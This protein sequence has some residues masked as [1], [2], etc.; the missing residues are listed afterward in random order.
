MPWAA[1]AAAASR[2]SALGCGDRDPIAR[3]LAIDAID[4]IENRSVDKR[5]HAHLDRHGRAGD[6]GCAHRQSGSSR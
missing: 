1:A 4:G 2:R 3:V 5:H 6:L